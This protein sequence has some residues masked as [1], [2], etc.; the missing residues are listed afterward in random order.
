MG[1]WRP[2][3][4]ADNLEN[5]RCA[6]DGHPQRALIEA[7]LRAGRPQRGIAGQ[8]GVT[9]TR[10]AFHAKHC[11]RGKGIPTPSDRRDGAVLGALPGQLKVATDAIVQVRRDSLEAQ[12]RQGLE[13][14]EGVRALTLRW[15][16]FA[17]GLKEDGSGD[18]LPA[19]LEAAND[20]MDVLVK[21]G[22]GGV[23]NWVELVG[24]ATGELQ[25]GRGTTVILLPSGQ[26]SK[27]AEQ[28]CETFTTKMLETAR[29]VFAGDPRLP[30]FL[31]EVA[32]VID[33]TGEPVP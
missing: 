24:K 3:G 32:N 13:Y 18:I 33:T 31:N 28:F 20:A 12:A 2:T 26:L 30:A 6:L 22:G 10:V 7:D 5:P 1:L 29:R 15:A 19:D 11:M 8:Y 17:L 14:A 21:A 25:T 4:V 27:E 23:R 9:K 16:H